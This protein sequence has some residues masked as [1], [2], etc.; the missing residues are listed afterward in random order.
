[1]TKIL[2]ADDHAI[3]RKGLSGLLTREFR[4][5][6]I[7]EADNAEQALVAV[8]KNRWDLLILDI[9]MP[10]RSGLDILR[11]VKGLQPNLPVLILTVYSED[12]LGRRALK[13]GA[14]GF[15][16][17]GAD[18]EELTTAIRKLLGGGMYVSS[19]LAE[20]IALNLSQDSDAPLH[21]KL[22]NRELE[23]LRMMASGKTLTQIAEALHLGV[24]TI[25]TY[26]AHLLEKLA[27]GT[28]AELIHY[29][30]QNNIVT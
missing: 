9:T 29:A 4:D 27:L 2:I 30:L 14:S 11:D 15:L 28:T 21:E 6:E 10:G 22:S 24:T 17:K 7:G 20:L 16:T 12:Q 3:L 26:R 23:V 18:P 19:A 5:L 8:R 25:S 13:A 1:M